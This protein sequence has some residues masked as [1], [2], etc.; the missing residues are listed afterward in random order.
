MDPA[1]HAQIEGRVEVPTQ[2]LWYPW[3]ERGHAS[4]DDDGNYVPPAV[5]DVRVG[6]LDTDGHP[7]AAILLRYGTQPVCP[8]G[9]TTRGQFVVVR[10]DPVARLAASILTQEL[11]QGEVL[12]HHRGHVTWTDANHDGHPDITV[13]GQSCSGD[14]PAPADAGPMVNRYGELEDHPWID[15]CEPMHDVYYWH[16]DTGTWL[17]GPPPARVAASFAPCH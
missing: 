6:D 12:P 13:M 7:E 5:L 3:P 10:A 14:M 15:Q 9:Y 8:V 17:L 16:P 4:D 2:D 11:P 1:G